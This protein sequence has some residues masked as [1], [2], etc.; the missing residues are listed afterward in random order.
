MLDRGVND[1]TPIYDRLRA[2]SN[3]DQ[4]VY[5]KQPCDLAILAQLRE[6]VR[7]EL[8]TDA[9]WYVPL[10]QV[11]N[12][13]QIDNAILYDADEFIATNEERRADDPA[14]RQY[15]VFGSSGNMDQY[16]YE[17][18]RSSEPFIVANFFDVRDVSESYPTLEVLLAALL[19][20]AVG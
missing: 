4:A 8:V 6:R 10:L 13:I 18:A 14:M 16:V 20:A 15:L 9:E 11:S 1:S 17:A 19:D 5:L 12:G 3:A 2:A 7:S